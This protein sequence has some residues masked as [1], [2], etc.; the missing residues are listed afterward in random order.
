MR[1]LVIG[2]AGF[3]GSHLADALAARGD[4]VTVVDDLSVGKRE[5]LEGALAGGLVRLE[6]LRVTHEPPVVEQLAGLCSGH[7]TVFHLAA[8]PEARWG[9]ADPFLDLRQNTLSAWAA[10]EAARRAGSKRF[11]LAS[12]G[13]VY[14]DVAEVVAEDHG[15]ILPI[16]L[17]GASKV[18]SEALVSAYAHCFGVRG[19]ILRFGNVVGPRG[20]HG[21]ALDF[22]RKLEA[23]PTRLEVLGDGR[24]RKPY[25]HVS[26]CVA[27]ILFALERAAGDVTYL[28]LAPPD[29]TAVSE[30]AELVVAEMGLAGRARIEFTGGTRGW[31]G[32]VPTSRLDP[33]KAAALGFRVRMSSGEAMRRAVRELIQ[34]HRPVG[35]V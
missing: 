20:T 6:V 33:G 11:V 9:L 15:P 32:D 2:G 21:A 19:V 30:I 1:A 16:S 7:D 26:D 34:E 27:G 24:Q 18:A 4:S 29:T 8:N 12:S 22:I 3:V 35:G 31:P 17:Y 5:F 23:D 25:L 10:L 28:N 13:T 14:G